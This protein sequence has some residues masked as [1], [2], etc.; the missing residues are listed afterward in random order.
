RR[1]P[2]SDETGLPSRHRRTGDV[3]ATWYEVSP[4]SSVT[5]ELS[6]PRIVAAST[7]SR[8]GSRKLLRSTA[9][10]HGGGRRWSDR[11][12]AAVDSTCI[13]TSP[14]PACGLAGPRPA[15]AAARADLPDDH[16]GPRGAA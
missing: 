5:W 9:T 1:A 11:S 15:H 4:G 2:R 16:G 7:L 12:N 10:C 3:A 8:I 6:A 13:R 14:R